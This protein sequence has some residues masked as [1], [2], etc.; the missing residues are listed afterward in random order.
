[1]TELK[2]VFA[3]INSPVPEVYF[4]GMKL[5]IAS[6]HICWD[7]ADEHGPKPIDIRIEGFIEDE[8]ITFIRESI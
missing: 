4:S 2:I 5:A 6:C 3:D 7:T 1:M 8:K